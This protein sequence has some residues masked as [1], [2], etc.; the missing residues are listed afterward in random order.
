MKLRRK[1]NFDICTY[2]NHKCTFC[3]NSDSRTIKDHVSLDDFKKVM[4]N[5]TKYVE[6]DE[7]G[8]SAKGEVLVNKEFAHII[9]SCKNDFN[10]GYK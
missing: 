4:Q 2:C 8:L 10:I 1:V 6:I 9:K 5:I 7:L 3:S